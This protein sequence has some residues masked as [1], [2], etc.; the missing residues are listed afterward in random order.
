LKTTSEEHK[1]ALNS[2]EEVFSLMKKGNLQDDQVQKALR[3]ACIQRFKYSIDIS[4]KT[5]MK[6]LASDIKA[7]KPAIREM[8]SNKL[9][10]N[11]EQWLEFIDSRIETSLAHDDEVAAKIILNIQKFLP[12]ANLLLQKLEQIK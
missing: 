2:L 6:I 8:A 12:E 1:K 11:P 4:W 5:C 3:D 7:A 10:S 9:I